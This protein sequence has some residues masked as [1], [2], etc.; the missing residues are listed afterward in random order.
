MRTRT[1]LGVAYHKL[2]VGEKDGLQEFKQ[3]LGWF[4]KCGES[5]CF[6]RALTGEL[7]I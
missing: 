2:F 5:P 6:T 3:G 7:E 4:K 1:P